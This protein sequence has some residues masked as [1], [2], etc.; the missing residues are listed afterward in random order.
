MSPSSLQIPLLHRVTQMDAADSQPPNRRPPFWLRWYC[1]KV[2]TRWRSRCVMDIDNGY[3]RPST[4][5]FSILHPRRSSRQKA[6]S[7]IIAHLSRSIRRGCWPKTISRDEHSSSLKEHRA[8][9]CGNEDPCRTTETLSPLL[10]LET[11]I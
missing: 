2:S 4:V 10:I 1:L 11:S 7:T 8:Y 6:S 5:W 3:H 9:T